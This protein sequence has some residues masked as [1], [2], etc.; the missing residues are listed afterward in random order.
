MSP[1]ACIELHFSPF[2]A[3]SEERNSV[4]V[5][6]LTVQTVQKV[7]N[8]T[9][10]N[11]HKRPVYFSFIALK[12]LYNGKNYSLNT[13]EHFCNSTGLMKEKPDKNEGQKSNMTTGRS[14]K[15]LRKNRK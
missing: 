15:Y 5:K 9:M 3:G 14:S 1:V 11:E 10:G 2:Y 6:L 7:R 13:V 12:E 4:Q 8:Y